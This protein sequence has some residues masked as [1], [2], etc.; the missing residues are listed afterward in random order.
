MD[1]FYSIIQIAPN[2]VAGDIISIGLLVKSKNHFWLQFSDEKKNVLKRLQP[3]QSNIIEFLSQQ[4][5]QKIAEINNQLKMDQ[6][7]LFNIQDFLNS[8]TIY[9][10]NKYSNGILRFSGPNELDETI[11]Y[12]NFQKLY[13]IF[14][15]NHHRK[16]KT[17]QKKESI[18][19]DNIFKQTIQKNLIRGI[20]HKIHTNLNLTPKII[21]GLYSKFE[22]DCIG[23]NGVLIGAKS[24]PFHK[25][26]ETIDKEIGHYFNFISILKTKYQP[27]KTDKNNT[28]K[29]YIIGDEP[30]EK[31]S[32]QH[33]IWENLVDNP[34][35]K[36]MNSEN[37]EQI[38]KEIIERKA[39]TFLSQ[40]NKF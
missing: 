21:P 19:I 40:T 24:I 9:Y 20:E 16:N 13:Q 36:L 32:P 26:H 28:D 18:E 8:E 29:F 27:D 38:A 6:I 1:T 14:I 5:S 34:A 15:D 23:K 10:L 3:M 37:S 7:D 25:S 39:T 31:N 35:I 11:N 2:P 22:I 33:K 4:I 30:S 17:E 12:E